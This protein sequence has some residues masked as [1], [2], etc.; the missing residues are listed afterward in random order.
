MRSHGM[1]YHLPLRR[2][3]RRG[4]ACHGGTCSVRRP[5]GATCAADARLRH[6]PL[7]GRR[8]LRHGLQRPVRGLRRRG[9]RGHLHGPVTGAPHGP[10]RPARAP[11]PAAAPATAPRDGVHVPGRRPPCAALPSCSGGHGHTAPPT[12]TAWA[13]APPAHAPCAPRHLRPRGAA[14][15]RAPRTPTAPRASSA[16]AGRARAASAGRDACTAGAQCATGNCVDGVCCDTACDGQCEACDAAGS[17]GTCT[18]VTG[19]PHGSRT[20]CNG[21]G[22]CAGTCD[23]T[24]AR[25]VRL[26]GHGRQLPRGA[27]TMGVAVGPAA[28]DGTGNCGSQPDHHVRARTR[29]QGAPVRPRA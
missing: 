12:V 4:A 23:G 9:L 13:P 20:A 22:T 6:R 25:R 2:G 21:T 27:C 17:V 14:W 5:P 16:T 15:P 24:R 7:R 3:L 1:R 8:V 19:A 18:A 26:P 29:A 11:A 28:C 10:A